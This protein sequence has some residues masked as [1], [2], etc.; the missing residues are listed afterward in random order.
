L[1][2]LRL[3]A[4]GGRQTRGRLELLGR[5]FFCMLRICYR[6]RPALHAPSHKEGVRRAGR[7]ADAAARPRGDRLLAGVDHGRAGARVHGGECGIRNRDCR[8]PGPAPGAGNAPWKRTKTCTSRLCTS[9]TVSHG[10]LAHQ[11]MAACRPTDL[12]LS[13]RPARA[14]RCAF[15]PRR[16]GTNAR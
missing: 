1:S 14:P 7:A 5:M 10:R 13:P 3:G 11:N 9:C 4:G 16:P 8:L 6:R 15:H 12:S 2:M